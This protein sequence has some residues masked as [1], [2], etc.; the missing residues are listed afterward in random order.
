MLLE[1]AVRKICNQGNGIAKGDK[2]HNGAAY[3][4]CQDNGKG[5]A[6]MGLDAFSGHK[7]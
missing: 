3:K 7:L 2:D 5:A 4:D 6:G 1:H